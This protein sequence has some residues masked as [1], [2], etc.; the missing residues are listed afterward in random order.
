MANISLKRCFQN[1]SRPP[2]AGRRENLSLREKYKERS[3][4]VDQK[5][6]LC[7]LLI[8]R[9]GTTFGAIWNYSSRARLK[10]KSENV[11]LD[12]F[13]LNNRR[14]L[15][16]IHVRGCI[17]CIQAKFQIR[18]SYGDWY[19]VKRKSSRTPMQCYRIG[20]SQPPYAAPPIYPHWLSFCKRFLKVL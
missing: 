19:T 9:W 17:L 11:N 15:P 2:A 8:P 20:A 1:D 7:V 5:R 16:D 10:I 6:I 3:K 12:K 13:C 18:S 14:S 4:F